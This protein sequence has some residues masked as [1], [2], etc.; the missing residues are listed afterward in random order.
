MTNPKKRAAAKRIVRPLTADEAARVERARGA[1]KQQRDQIQRGGQQQL[2]TWMAMRK[3]VDATI[4][5]LKRQR[6]RLGLSLADV[7]QR[8]GLRKSVLSRLE[9]DKRANPTLL[10]L[11]RY[12][13][14]VQLTLTTHL[15]H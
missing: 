6:E 14:A 1:V 13:T 15:N 10:T 4:E 12:V 11:Q 7:E 9:N 5:A 2:K 3:D 8:S